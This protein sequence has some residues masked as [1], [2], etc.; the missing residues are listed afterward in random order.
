MDR[1]MRAFFFVWSAEDGS[2]MFVWNLLQYDDLDDVTIACQMII[3]TV[4]SISIQNISRPNNCKRLGYIL[5]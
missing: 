2:A 4:H 1:L 3:V 5:D